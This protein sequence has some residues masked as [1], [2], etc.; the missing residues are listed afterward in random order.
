MSNRLRAAVAAACLGLALAGCRSAPPSERPATAQPPDRASLAAVTL[1]DLSRMDP[2]VQAQARERFATLEQ[3]RAAPATS[4]ADLATA[5]GEYAVLLHAAEYYEAA[6]PAYLNAQA[7]QPGDLR[8]P[9]YLG[10][11]YKS[12]GDTGQAIQ[13]FTRAYIC[14]DQYSGCVLITRAR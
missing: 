12:E 4:D 14:F 10:H 2:P 1:P 3:R 13:S 5:F 8:W 9:Y 6:L 7:L 11:L